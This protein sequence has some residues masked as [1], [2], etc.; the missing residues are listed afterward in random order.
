MLTYPMMKKQLFLDLKKLFWWPLMSKIMITIIW[1]VLLRKEEH[2]L[3]SAA[4]P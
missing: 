3:T 2:L 4:V 1:Q